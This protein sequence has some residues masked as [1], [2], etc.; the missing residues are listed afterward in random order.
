[1][2]DDFFSNIIAALFPE[3]QIS[4]PIRKKVREIPRGDIDYRF[5][6][7]TRMPRPYWQ[8]RWIEDGNGNFTGFYDCKSG[9]VPGEIIRRY[10][11]VYD[12]YV[13]NPP[14]GFIFHPKHFCFHKEGNNKWKV[15]FSKNPKDVSTGVLM[16]EQILNKC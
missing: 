6:I 10:D 3:K 12:Y 2:G 9:A 1:M 4:I 16:I 8:R 11:G 14:Q 5:R 7:V 15:H 13:L